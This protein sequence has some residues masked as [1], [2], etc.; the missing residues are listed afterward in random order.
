MGRPRNPNVPEDGY[1]SKQQF[2]ETGSIAASD[3]AVVAD[4]D[5]KKKVV[6]EPK[7]QDTNTTIHVLSPHITSD[8]NVT[9]PAVSGTLLTAGTDNP[10]FAIMQPITGTSPTATT[11]SDTL[12]FTSSDTTVQIIGNSST[13]TLDFKIPVTSAITQ[14]TGD[15]TATGPGSV[16]FTLATVNGN[17]GTFGSST[18]IPS[19][20]VNAKGLVTAAS[21]NAVIAPAGTLTG[22]TLNSTVVTS[23]LTS[24]GTQSAPLNMGSHL[25]SAVTD[26]VSAQDAATKNYV[27]AVAQGLSA[28]T[29]A[30]V[31]TTAN[32]TLSGE[33][34]I[35]GVPTSS[36][37]VLVKNQSTASQNGIY[38]SS[39]GAW[40]RST[41][42]DTGAE[43]A[44]AFVF[45]EEGTINSSTGW[46]QITQPPI[47]IG[48]T[49]IVWTQFSGAGTYTADGQGV[50]LSGTQFSLSIDGTTL[51]QSASGVKVATGGITNNEI[52]ASAAIA[53]S[54]LNLSNSIVN[55]D[56]N[57][58]AG[59]V[60]TKLATISTAGKVLNSATTATSANTASAIVARDGSGN[61]SA[62]T[63][64]AA[65][66]GTASGNPPN[67]RLIN[68]TAPLAGGGDLSADRTISIPKATTSVDGYLAATDFTTFNN[69]QT[70]GNYITAL[71]GDI[72]ATGPGSVS[73]TLATVNGNVG[74]FGSSTSIPS[75]TVNDKGLVTAASGNVVIAPAG[76][77]TGTTL[78]SNVVSSSLTSVGTIS[79]GTW[80]G[81][82]ID[83]AHGGTNSST[84]LN[85][86]RIMQSSGGAIVEAPAITASR[87][88]K[89]DANGIPVASTATA[90]SIDALSGTNTGD[91]TITLTGDVTGSGTGSFA[92]TIA[93][94]A[95]TDQKSSLLSKPSVGVVATSN[96][97]LSGEQTID[98]VTTVNT[99]V[100]ASAQ[101]SGSQNGPWV[102]NSGAWTRPTWYTSGST[103][104]AM[105]FITTLVRLGTVYQG[106]TWRSTTANPITIDTTA[107]VWVV[108]PHALNANTVISVLPVANGGTGQSSYTNGQ[109]LIGNT[110]GNTLAKSTLTA[111]SG[112]TVT[113]GGGTITIAA[114]GASSATDVQVFTG[115]GTWT[116]PSGAK[117]VRCTVIGGG[118]GGGS[119]SFSTGSS[120]SG[121]S[122]GGG[123]SPATSQYNASD[124]GA[125]VTITVGA[126][127]IAGTAVSG[128]AGSG[129]DGG[130]GGNSSFGT[131][132]TS[133]GGG[134][135]AG[136][137]VGTSH[138]GGTGAGTAGAG[139]PGSGGSSNG[140]LPSQ[141]TGVGV[142]GAGAGTTS[143]TAPGNPSE[144]GGGSG[145]GAQN[146][147]TGKA[148][149]TS[150]FGCG[151]G[152][153]GGGTN[154]TTTD[155]AGGAGGGVGQFVLTGAGGGA[156]G[157]AG[158]GGTP[159]N[160]TA[161]T[162]T[163]L[164][165]NGAGGGGGGS[166][167][168]STASGGTGGVGGAYGGGGGGGGGGR[169]L[170][171][172][173][174]SGA[175]GAGGAGVVIVAT[176]F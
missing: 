175:G 110:T 108:T 17:V 56:I 77:L 109:L 61:F 173:G 68:T 38:V 133:Y 165:Y 35:D 94:G 111:G 13:N 160:G 8:I 6:F 21:G 70:A 138:A 51:S 100:L 42:A 121:G 4:Y 170:S 60:D 151:G 31:A 123:A 88:L 152:G 64:T 155:F 92:A 2:E 53:Y 15:G 52:N 169:L 101:S 62:G 128:A 82:V 40:S 45:V 83:I 66:T 67:S 89:S 29:S 166:S 79:S 99:L 132:L 140:G 116:K 55:A 154:T 168:L 96:L 114:T 150:I 11:P 20:T 19:V 69:K 95:V 30:L 32:I 58:S 141:S 127:G 3:F 87:A 9:W 131:Q 59:I 36:S 1:I 134:A 49:S 71:T 97:T 50:K 41:D 118:G 34:T 93:T 85:N 156:G 91:Q 90:A 7:A 23:S 157:A 145:G 84:A 112:I 33:Q 162:A 43:L 72:T 102:S 54:K 80:N 147:G 146:V 139:L 144:N 149:G 143:V 125:T 27:D 120:Q 122:G 37:R 164:L 176:F 98:G 148:G 106:S 129:V 130:A 104:Q 86:N 107:T 153:G 159:G 167:A 136:G 174:S 103:T 46:T 172:A 137:S 14:L 113:N 126:A 65:L 78:A 163:S 73:A 76:T 12:T 105:Q 161:G 44:G 57:A 5:N 25:I 117:W 74:S 75:F 158:A 18:S 22:T 47:T 63:I 26:P 81:S 39:S 28:K 48:I 24:L 10:S 16:P 115:S 135:G 124:L 119:G 142:A 171:G